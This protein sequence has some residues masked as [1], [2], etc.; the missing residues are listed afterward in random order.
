MR[1]LTRSIWLWLTVVGCAV[2]LHQ[3]RTDPLQAPTVA[4]L[5]ARDRP[6]RCGGATPLLAPG[7]GPYC[8]GRD[9]EAAALAIAGAVEGGLTAVAWTQLP[10][11]TEADLFS[12]GGRMVPLVALQDLW[13]Y[14]AMRPGLDRQLREGLPYT[15]ADDLDHLLVAPFHRD[16]MK[17]PAVFGGILVLGGAA[18]ALQLSLSPPTQLGARPNLF[19]TYPPPAVGYPAGM[20]LSGGLMTHVAIAEEVAFR[21]LIQSGLVRATNETGGWALGSLVFGASHAVNVVAIPKEERLSYLTIAV[22]WIT[23]TGS[24]MG[25]VYRWNDY[26]LTGPV[27]THFWYNVIVSGAAFAADPENH[28]FSARIAFRW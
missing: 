17:R 6:V 23:L 14:S 1:H 26:S 18:T 3:T 2:P 22:P 16:V 24:W 25:L 12:A 13:V 8:S 7:L 28:L 11:P 20:L 5:A 15:P 21:G 19:G 27:A 4:E 9:A 10:A